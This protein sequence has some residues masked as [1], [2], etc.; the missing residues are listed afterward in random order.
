MLFDS[1]YLRSHAYDYDFLAHISNMM[2]SPVIF[3]F[4]KF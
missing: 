4:S 2:I 3:I 1:V